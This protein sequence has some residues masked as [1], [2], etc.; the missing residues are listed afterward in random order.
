MQPFL[1][2]HCTMCHSAKAKVANLD[3]EKYKNPSLV[4]ANQEIWDKIVRKIRTGEMPPKGRPAP[5]PADIKAVT[6]WL[7]AEY[8]R[9]DKSGKHDPGR[10]TARRLNRPEYNNTIRD[11]TGLDLR[12]ADQFPI[13]DSGYGFDNIGD[14]L[15]VSP[16]LMEKYLTAADRITK[17]AIALPKVYKE[18]SDRYR[19]DRTR[20][21][22][23]PGSM[24]VKHAFPIEA[25]Y[26]IRIAVAG[27]RS[28]EEEGL[29]VVAQFDGKDEKTIDAFTPLNRPRVLDV[30]IR[31]KPGSHTIRAFLTDS[32]GKPF[33][34]DKGLLVEYIE[35]RGPR[36]PAPFAPP[37][38][39]RQIL[40]CGEWPGKYDDACMRAIVENFARR[41]FRR[42]V[43][44]R[45]VDGFVRYAKAA[46][47]EGEVPEIA[48]RYSLQAIL[49]APQFLFRI[50]R[51]AKPHDPDARHPIDEFELA[52]RLSYFLWSSM[53]SDTLFQLAQSKQLRKPGVLETQVQSMLAD[54][55]FTG[56]IDN[57]VGQWLELRN[58]DE[59]KPAP[60]K[61]PA[62]DE[63]L[64][65]AMKRE[66]Q[67]FFESV[68][69]E[70]RSIVDFLDA[71]YTFLNERLARHYGIPGVVGKEFRKVELNTPQ[72][73]G[74]LTMASVLTVSS[75]P[76]RTSPVIRGKFLL[77]NFLN[78]PPPPPPPDVPSLEESAVGITGTLRQQM[79]KH[80]AN[81]ICASCHVRMDALGFGLE[82]YDATGA[83]RDKDGS[84]PINA[85]GS[86][87][88]GLTFQT[89]SEL[90]AILKSEKD[91]FA[92]CL[93]EK[94]LTY[95]L[96]RGLEK[97]DR[98][99][100]RQIVR[101][102]AADNY[103]FSRLIREV[104]KS[105]AFQSRRGEAKDD[106]LT[107]E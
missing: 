103:R 98:T 107:A 65:Q 52:S 69:K 16:A 86:L 81:A 9:Y 35:V 89:P 73:G 71:R 60:E 15:S 29:K 20:T 77:E 22:G 56:F 59:V 17:A 75:Y 40:I 32:G 39:H 44:P 48:L 2:K 24:E 100:V 84:F 42:P 106:K 99:F 25:D 80:R 33:Q 66:T 95:A 76:N 82:N 21:A 1:A 61:F 87:P 91:D 5:A 74:L 28:T 57:F 18:T 46:R 63:E 11:L 58:L 88:G 14:V 97:N 102:V 72:R 92:Q 26:D 93:A 31:P 54:S 23:F 94:L 36:N 37:P 104:V 78:A 50:E 43:T 64:R 85:A 6:E 34:E 83:W 49:V 3:L 47:D 27:R 105:P 79:E 45:E 96:G 19:S 51:D 55:R 38:S 68:V 8:A 4:L 7:Q 70:D 67:L 101:S 53:P 13:D 12:P 10:V 41:A 90:K 30:Q 62:F